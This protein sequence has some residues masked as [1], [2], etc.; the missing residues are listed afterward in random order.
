MEFRKDNAAF[1]AFIR[2][3]L[4]LAAFGARDILA[5]FGKFLHGT[6]DQFYFFEF[7]RVEPDTFTLRA[8]VDDHHGVRVTKCIKWLAAPGTIKRLFAGLGTD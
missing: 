7:I 8:H 5:L 3:A 6:V 2:I 1:H 4:G